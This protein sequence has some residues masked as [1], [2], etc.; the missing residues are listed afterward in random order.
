LIKPAVEGTLSVLRAAQKHKVKRVV[1]TSSG[2]TIYLKKEAKPVLNEDDWSDPESLMPYE[3]S[4]YLAEKAAWNFVNSLPES[5][6]FELVVC[7]PGL[8][9]GPALHY[10]N[11]VS[12]TMMKN[13]LLGVM[14]ALP[15]VRFGVVDVRDVAQGHLQALK[16][17]AARNNRFILI[18]KTFTFK[19]VAEL[20]KERYGDTFPIKTEEMAECPPGNSRFKLLWGRKFDM[21]H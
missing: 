13:H 5:E 14:P 6:K 18:L 15:Q 2:L 9:Q 20:L 1:I 17:D 10:T 12:S 19:E 21:N 8:V 3:K 7:I 16:V 11:D 4:K